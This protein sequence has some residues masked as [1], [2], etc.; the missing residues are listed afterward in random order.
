MRQFGRRSASS[1]RRSGDS[2][3]A[4]VDELRPLTESL[5]P[6][7]RTVMQ[8]RRIGETRSIERVSVELSAVMVAVIGDEPH[9]LTMTTGDDRAHGLPSGPLESQHRT[10]E[11]G[12][13][14]WIAEHARQPVGYIEQLYTFGDRDR[15]QNDAPPAVRPLSIGYLALVPAVSTLGE[16]H[17]RWHN[18][19]RYF[20]WEDWRNGEPNSLAAI[21]RVCGRWVVE[22]TGK[23]ERNAR[24]ARVQGAFGSPKERWNEERV[25]ERYELLFEIGFVPEAG[26]ERSHRDARSHQAPGYGEPMLADHR[27]ILATAISRLR[28]KIK[29]RPVIFELMPASFTLSQL[30]ATVEGLAGIRLHKPNFRRL[31]ESQ[32]LVE[33]TGE[34][35]SDTLGRPARLVRF[36]REVMLEHPGLAGR[37]PV[38]RHGRSRSRR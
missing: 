28:G 25:L 11:L 17:A 38:V 1:L 36:R 31:V 4:I 8:G 16:M 22:A 37:L 33:A 7:F 14:A 9:A 30:Q 18:W 19:Y 35:T 20:P 21:R 12:L 27:R 13:R 23:A 34:L 29:Y 5:P 6:R 3:V 2:I 32:G 10:L 24:A 26:R 15:Q